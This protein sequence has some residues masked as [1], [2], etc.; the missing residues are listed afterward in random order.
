MGKQEKMNP[1]LKDLDLRARMP[2]TLERESLRSREPLKSKTEGSELFQI[3]VRDVDS[4]QQWEVKSIGDHGQGR[5]L[6]TGSMA[7]EEIEKS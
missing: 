1:E 2:P 4:S 3:R 7:E 6:G 5:S